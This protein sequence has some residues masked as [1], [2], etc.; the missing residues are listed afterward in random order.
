MEW[1]QCK[2]DCIWYRCESEWQ[3]REGGEKLATV[4]PV[5]GGFIW[6][7]RGGATGVTV[8]LEEAQAQAASYYTHD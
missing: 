7:T 8:T 1:Q 6:E 4:Y 2:S 3:Y 5:G